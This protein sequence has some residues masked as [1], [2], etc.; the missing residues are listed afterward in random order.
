MEFYNE[1]YT[2]YVI[3]N[4][5][6]DEIAH[7]LSDEFMKFESLSWFTYDS[8]IEVKKTCNNWFCFPPETYKFF[9]Y[10]NSPAF[11]A[12]L[13]H[14][15]GIDLIPDHGMHGAGWHI[16]PSG[17]K[18]N[19]HL[20]YSIHPKLHLERRINFIYYLTPGWD[21]SWG[22]NLEMWS[23]DA[24]TNQPKELIKTVENKFNRAVLFDTAQNSWHG[25]S[26]AITCP[27]DKHR[28]SIAMYYLCEP[29]TGAA[30]RNRALFAPTNEQKNDDEIKKLIEQRVK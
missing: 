29:S 1:P 4:F 13:S 20:D 6:D 17:G 7:K 24:E 15:T 3:D 10:L 9:Q 30:Q 28:K 19:V 26:Q 22:G 14:L 2:H 21:T 25:F 27:T 12:S 8:A 5:V 18:L 23:H 16:Q 11:V